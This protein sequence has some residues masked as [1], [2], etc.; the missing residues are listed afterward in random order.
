[1]VQKQL[2]ST[3]TEKIDDLTAKLEGYFVNKIKDDSTL[4]RKIVSFHANKKLANFRWYKYKEAF[5][6][7]LI[8]H[9]IGLFELEGKKILDPFAGIGTT[10]F[11]SSLL[12]CKATGIELLPLGQK[13]IEARSEAHFQ[14]IQEYQRPLERIIKE[15]PW[16]NVNPKLS[17]NELRITKD[18]YPKETKESIEKFNSY[19]ESCNEPYRNLLEL[20]LLSVLE[21]VSFTRKDGQYLRWDHRAKRSYGKKEFNKGEILDF[22][23]AITKKLNEIISDISCSDDSLFQQEKIKPSG[24]IELLKGSSLDILPSQKSN[25]YQAVITSPPYCNRYDYTRTY[26]LE[27][28]LLGTDEKGFTELRQRMLT[29]TVENKEKNLLEINKNWEIPLKITNDIELLNEIIGY[30]ENLKSEKKLNNNGIVRMVKGYFLEMACIIYEMFRVLTRNG[31]VVM[32]NDNVR[33][34]GIEI[35]VDIIL[36]KIAE[37]VGFE[38]IN[39]LVLPQKK[40][41]S[42]QQMGN[43]GRKELRKCVYIWRKK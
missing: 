3:T 32:V 20:A 18:A 4:S 19:I 15:T 43:H 38:I 28:A 31:Y 35:P 33:Y 9:F 29:C 24:T 5:S 12:G 8:E 27:L 16:E 25:T 30:L 22:K 17:M 14:D 11:S 41:N 39:I 6:A 37:E 21:D 36:S 34:A 10:L 1:M 2:Y 40:G 42:S 13:I 23:T 26:A 7:S